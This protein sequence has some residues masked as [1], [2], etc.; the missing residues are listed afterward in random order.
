MTKV[1]L[2]GL[3]RPCDIEAVNELQP[4]YIGFVFWKKSKRCITPEL[5]MELRSMLDP[6]ITA[7]GVFLDEELPVV[8]DYLKR[9]IIDVAQLHGSEDE[10]FIRQVKEE[11]GKSV[12]RAFP[13]RCEEDIAAAEASIA[14]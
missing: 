5:A 7:V 4:E 10:D 3:S 11:T 9:G 14:D 2:C 8:I 13:I 1:K 12:I 6:K